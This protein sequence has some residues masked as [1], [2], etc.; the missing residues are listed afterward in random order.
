MLLCA[1]ICVRL[2]SMQ[3]LYAPS[4]HAPVSLLV[5]VCLCQSS[6]G[7]RAR[8]LSRARLLC[9]LLCVQALLEQAA[10]KESVLK[11]GAISQHITDISP[12]RHEI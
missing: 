10:S 11:A 5:L 12:F 7:W 1:R 9:S 3:V 4:T 8:S 6:L 2:L